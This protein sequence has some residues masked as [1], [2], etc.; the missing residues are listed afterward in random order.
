MKSGNVSLIIAGLAIVIITAALFLYPYAPTN[1]PVANATGHTQEGVERVVH[2]NNQFAINMFLELEKTN[3]NKNVF[4]SPYSISSAF[5]LVYEGA[6]GDTANEIASVFHFPDREEL[7]PNFAWI[8]NKINEKSDKYTLRTGNALWVQKDFPLMK[9]YVERVESYY[10]GKAANL[11]FNNEPEK[12]RETINSFIEEQTNGKIKDL[13]PASAI[14]PDTVLII[15]NAIYFKGTW[16]WQFDKA[17]TRDMEFKTPEGPVTVK[18]MHMKPDKARFNYADV[19]K[20]EILELP[21]KGNLSMIVILPKQG[22][23]IDHMTGERKIY[24]YTIDDIEGELSYEKLKSWESQM[25]KTH[26]DGIYLPKFKLE[27][28]YSL[29]DPLYDMGIKKAFTPS[30]NFSEMT[31]KRVFI[32][33]VL[34]KAYVDVNEE[35]TE[36][37]AAT[38]IG[39]V[40][41]VRPTHIFKADHPF[42]FLI[43]DNRTGLILFMGKMVDPSKG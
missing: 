31:P 32:S 6:R 9:E 8:Y 35:G 40:T 11:D 2:A 21:Y 17:E 26:L 16:V 3:K 27:T 29:S 38:A 12:S 24:N 18:M 4:F 20:A 39:M 37:A 30:A 14:T 22:E 41:A 23:M 33:F 15:T 25:I 7:A 5:G 19:G 1:P 43:K 34:H 36:A 10:G 13:L 28:S 42:I